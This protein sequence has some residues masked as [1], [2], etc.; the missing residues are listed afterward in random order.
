MNALRPFLSRLISPLISTFATWLSVRWAIELDAASQ[1]Q[2]T[3]AVLVIAITVGNYVGQTVNNVVHRLIDKRL[4][5]GDAAS[6]HLAEKEKRET[7][8]LKAAGGP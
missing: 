6:S 8:Q 2:I 1:Q 5:P 3:A 7:V 4:N